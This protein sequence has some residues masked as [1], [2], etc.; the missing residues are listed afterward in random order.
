MIDKIDIQWER[1]REA[2]DYMDWFMPAW[3]SLSEDDRY[4]LDEFYS[5]DHEYG[6]GTVDA[7]AEHFNI[8]RASA[9]RRKNRAVERLAIL[10]YGK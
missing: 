4:I 8:E 9:Y 2:Q 7:I 10:L 3:N 6:D 1:Y 5:K